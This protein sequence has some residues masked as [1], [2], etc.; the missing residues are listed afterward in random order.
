V[1]VVELPKPGGANAAVGQVAIRPGVVLGEAI[2]DPRIIPFLLLVGDEL[3]KRCLRGSLTRF[4][5]S[6]GLL[7]ARRQG[8]AA[9][10]QSEGLLRGLLYALTATTRYYTPLGP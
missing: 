6:G 4:K 5:G 8:H 1:W 2:Q 7:G 9:V 10:K 3:I